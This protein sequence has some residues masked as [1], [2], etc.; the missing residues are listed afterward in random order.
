M[1]EGTT[2]CSSTL[3][4]VQPERNVMVRTALIIGMMAIASLALAKER[5]LLAKDM[6][7]GCEAASTDIGFAKGKTEGMPKGLKSL[8]EQCVQITQSLIHS[9]AE[10]GICPK[11]LPVANIVGT[12]S[13]VFYL[14]EFPDDMKRPFSEVAVTALQRTFPCS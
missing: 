14:M 1:L 7:K 4:Q 8:A 6:A 2:L 13:V 10:H 9:G 12:A 5:S 11:K 3:E